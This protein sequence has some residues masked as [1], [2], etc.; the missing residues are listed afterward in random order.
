MSATQQVPIVL[1]KEGT[2][3]TKG[4]QAQRNNI[5]AAKTV[6]EIV[7]T[8]LGPRGMDKML[9]DTLGDVTISNDGATIL[10]EI[11]VQHPSAKMMVEISKSTDNEVGDGTT[12]TVVLAGSLLEKAEELITKNVHPTVVVE[13][14]KKASQKA[15]ETL[16]E[17]ATKVDPTDK[18]FLNKIAKTSMASKMVSADSKELA[19][20]VVDAVLAVAEKSGDKYKIDIDNVKVEKKA[21]G[22]IRDTEFI[23]GV[24]LDKEVVHGGMPKRI[25]NAKIAVINSPLE[26]E[27]TEFDAKININSPDQMQKFIDEENKM[28]KAMVDKVVAAG[29]S[30]LLCQKGID[31]IAQHYLANAGILAVRRIKESDMYKLSKATGARIVNN[32]DELS[33]SDLGY[34]K[35]AEERKVE[36]VKWVFVEECKNP[37]SV[38]ILIRGGSQRVVY[39]AERSVHDAIMTVKDVVEY[40]YV[41]VGGG[42]PEAIASMK[43]RDW[44]SSLS[45][46]AQLAAEKFADGIETIP[47]VLA[48]NAGMDPLDTQV[49]LRSK[50]TSGRARFGIDVLN[51]KVADLAAKDIYEPL[52]VKEQVINAATEAACMILR[53]DDVIAASKSKD[54]P[55]PGGG[56]GGGNGD[57]DM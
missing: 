16:K 40:P 39:E 32:L 26:I 4:N 23:H 7:R 3:E 49:Q 14:F 21:G 20:M 13:G 8:S 33:A 53:I 1:L 11:D 34:A 47:I 57:M 22:S 10:K 46:R 6:A 52:A 2:S 18:A 25:E 41:L 48:E 44:A 9:V 35:L 28:L 27:K 30:V 54:M 45:G 56:M 31:D 37:K 42:A 43:L 51:G 19:D 17:I 55:K 15:I 50:S 36:T 29:A 38:S 5:T 12:S 24:V